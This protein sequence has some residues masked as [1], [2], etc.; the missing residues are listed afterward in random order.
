MVALNQELPK[1]T[2]WKELT[3]EAAA[4]GQKFENIKIGDKT[5]DVREYF[6]LWM[7]KN[8][9]ESG[10]EL[11]PTKEGK[12]IIEFSKMVEEAPIW[13]DEWDAEGVLVSVVNKK[14]W[15]HDFGVAGVTLH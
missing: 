9:K 4:R 6:L 15:Q 5:I 2:A 8:L 7:L 3:E 11:V 1:I 10:L 14:L 12:S 13:K